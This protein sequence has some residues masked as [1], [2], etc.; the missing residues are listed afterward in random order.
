MVAYNWRTRQMHTKTVYHA[1]MMIISLICRAKKKKK[2]EKT[3]EG[4][5]NEPIEN[6]LFLILSHLNLIGDQ[7]IEQEKEK[8]SK[9]KRKEK[10]LNQITTSSIE[11]K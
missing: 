4:E 11:F 6:L 9:K 8:R 3:E 7:I 5:D 1:E 2:K 10:M